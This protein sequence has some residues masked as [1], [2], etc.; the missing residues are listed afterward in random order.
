MLRLENN[1][2]IYIIKNILIYRKLLNP[3]RS[4]PRTVTLCLH[5]SEVSTQLLLWLTMVVL[6]LPPAAT[7]LVPV[8]GTVQG[9]LELEPDSSASANSHLPECHWNQLPEDTVTAENPKGHTTQEEPEMVAVVYSTRF[10]P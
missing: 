2:Y 6:W 8:A 9:A 10:S 3:D 5:R 1:L 4:L 7:A